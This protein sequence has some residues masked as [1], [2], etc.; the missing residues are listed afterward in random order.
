MY[1]VI[2]FLL[3]GLLIGAILKK[4]IRS[5]KVF[6]MPVNIALYLLLFTLG[7]SAGSNEKITSQLHHLGLTAFLIS[8][9]VVVC[10]ACLAYLLY[11]YVFLSKE[12]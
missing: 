2:G 11:K 5:P 1:L 6:D 8:A 3:I 7:I 10:C 4:H 9:I 12:P